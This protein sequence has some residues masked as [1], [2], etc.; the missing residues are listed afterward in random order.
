VLEPEH[1]DLFTVD[2]LLSLHRQLQAI[3]PSGY[4]L[5]KELTD[6]LVRLSNQTMGSGEIL[7]SNWRNLSKEQV[8]G[9]QLN[10]AVG[11][12]RQNTRCDACTLYTSYLP[13]ILILLYQIINVV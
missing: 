5:G 1:P 8:S 13:I 9:C 10:S 4:M 7:P 11:K 3:A 12:G 6:T 2:Q